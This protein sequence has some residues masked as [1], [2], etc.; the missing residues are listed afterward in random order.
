MQGIPSRNAGPFESE[1][2]VFRVRMQGLPSL[3]M[4]CQGPAWPGS[5]SGQAGHSEALASHSAGGWEQPGHRDWQ[6]LTVTGTSSRAAATESSN[7]RVASVRVRVAN[8]AARARPSIKSES[9]AAGPEPWPDAPAQSPRS[10]RV[11]GSRLPWSVIGPGLARRVIAWRRD[12]AGTRSS[13]S[14]SGPSCWWREGAR[15]SCQRATRGRLAAAGR[16]RRDPDRERTQVGQVAGGYPDG[17]D[18]RNVSGGWQRRSQ[19]SC[20]PRC[21]AVIRGRWWRRWSERHK[22]GSKGSVLRMEGGLGLGL[23]NQIAGLS[24]WLAAHPTA[25]RVLSGAWACKTRWN[26]RLLRGSPQS[27]SIPHHMVGLQVWK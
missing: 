15:R 10:I 2:R 23:Q 1:R 19:Q 13:A 8:K 9:D 20:A 14:I 12:R 7:V 5:E 6:S 4:P 25:L 11:I 24:W 16:G 27:L 22:R 17:P 21:A 26:L 18:V 3:W